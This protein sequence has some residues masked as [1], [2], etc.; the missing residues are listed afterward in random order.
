MLNL[1]A[2]G[3]EFFNFVVDADLLV[4]QG[5]HKSIVF[6]KGLANVCLFEA[7][8]H[9]FKLLGRESPTSSHELLEVLK[10]F[11]LNIPI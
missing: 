3:P 9:F 1:L 8:P 2:V 6:L 10:F 5:G 7:W 4:R 11:I